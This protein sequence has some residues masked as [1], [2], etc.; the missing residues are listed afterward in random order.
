[1][2]MTERDRDWT[3][4]EGI[5]RHAI[6]DPDLLDHKGCFARLRMFDYGWQKNRKIDDRLVCLDLDMIIVNYLDPLFDRAEDF[7]ILG[8][9]H[10]VNPCPYNGSV[11]MLRP[12]RHGEVWTDFSIE[13]AKAIKYYQFPDDQAWFAAKIP[14]AATWPCGRKSG[15]Y[16]FMKPGWPFDHNL[17]NNARIVAFP[18]AREPKDFRHLPWVKQYWEKL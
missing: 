12:G 4:P 1:M 13:K 18:G 7:V 3:P 2:V 11:F 16:A 9:G 15:I 17:P 14:N 5:E 6:K 8:G 10:S